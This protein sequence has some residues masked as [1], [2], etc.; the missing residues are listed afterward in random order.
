MWAVET[1]DEGIALLTGRE[2]G[3]AAPDGSYPED[4]VHGLV[5]TRLRRNLEVLKELGGDASANGRLQ[6]GVGSVDTLGSGVRLPLRG[7][8]RH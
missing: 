4:S 7:A 8:R 5:Q 2:A 6:R 3:E 1:I